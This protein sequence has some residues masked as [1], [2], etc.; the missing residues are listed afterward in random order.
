MITEG[1]ELV[2]GVALGLGLLFL[3]VTTITLVG[4]LLWG[5]VTFV[6][7]EIRETLAYARGGPK[8]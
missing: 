4:A 1:I 7:T 8:K 5:L 2:F 6:C 3:L